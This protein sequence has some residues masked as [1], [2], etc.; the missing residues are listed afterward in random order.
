LLQECL[1][2]L[3]ENAVRYTPAGGLVRLSG[4][5]S[6]SPWVAIEDTGPG[7][8]ESELK[9]IFERFYRI[10]PA[11]S[12]RGSGLGLSIAQE[13]ANLHGAE[14]RVQSRVGIGSRFEL[15]LPFM[16]S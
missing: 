2:N 5:T 11:R 9:R 4:G 12:E 15:R 8:P 6:P 14:I 10:D 7:I 3:I 16:T 1:S 13:I